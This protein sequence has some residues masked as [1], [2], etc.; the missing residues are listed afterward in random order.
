MR[1][2]LKAEL[3]L[4]ALGMAVTARG[5]DAAGVVAH[6]DHG[7]Q[8]GLNRRAA[9]W[10]ARARSARRRPEEALRA[11]NRR[12]DAPEFRWFGAPSE[13][14]RNPSRNY[15]MGGTRHCANHALTAAPLRI[16]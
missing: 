8:P 12:A 14:F 9:A 6:S 13:F 15:Q 1:D 7:S 4:D 11:R 3:V 2:D 5:G 10:A 16:E